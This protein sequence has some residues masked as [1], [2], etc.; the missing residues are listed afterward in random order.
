MEPFGNWMLK[1][2]TAG[3]PES[4]EFAPPRQC[5]S[6][7]SHKLSSSV[8]Q[9]LVISVAYLSNAFHLEIIETIEKELHKTLLKLNISLN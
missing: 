1:S 3:D 6:C 5:R 4:P 7:V 8:N 2:K 9:F